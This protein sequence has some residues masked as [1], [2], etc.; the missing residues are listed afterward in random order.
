VREF[1]E[2]SSCAESG[3]VFS[4]PDTEK[5]ISRLHT[6]KQLSERTPLRL[7]CYCDEVE[8]LGAKKIHITEA[9]RKDA[10]DVIIMIGPEGDFSR[11]EIAQAIKSGWQP[12]S[13]GESRL[14]IETVALT[15]VAAV[16]LANC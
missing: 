8:S 3:K 12:V 13:L 7:I 10:S 5:V 11:E 1:L 14:R 15:A 6:A 2:H 9:L 4:C 16:Y